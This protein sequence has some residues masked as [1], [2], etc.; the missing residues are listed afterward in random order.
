MKT[1]K[2]Q[3]P[4]SIHFLV[5]FCVV[6]VFEG[7][8]GILFYKQVRVICLA[9]FRPERRK[10]AGGRESAISRQTSSSLV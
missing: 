9:A 6:V 10:R 2:S 8:G 3:F 4:A 7:L 1:G 5:V